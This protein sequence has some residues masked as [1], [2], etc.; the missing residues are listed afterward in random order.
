MSTAYTTRQQPRRTVGGYVWFVLMMGGWTAFFSLL[1]FSQ[2]MLED[3]WREVRDL[4]FVVEALVWLALF[5]LVLATAVW[6][7]SWE[8]S[9]RL[10]LVCAFALVWSTMFF[11]RK[12]SGS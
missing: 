7:S 5:P 9:L 8:T 6:E 1:L 4:P 2:A 10:A 11:P 3:I 12:T